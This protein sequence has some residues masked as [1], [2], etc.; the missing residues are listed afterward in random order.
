[1]TGNSPHH[2][3]GDPAELAA[4]FVAGAMPEEFAA[5]YQAHVSGCEACRREL[6]RLDGVVE[7]LMSDAP[8]VTPEAGAR[9]AIMA[10]L[11]EPTPDGGGSGAAANPQVWKKWPTTDSPTALYVLRKD[12]GGWEETGVQGVRVR[13]LHVDQPRN[14]ITM[15]VRMDAGAAYPR[16]VHN[17]P[18][19]CLVLEGDLHIVDE[20]VVLNAGDY[21]CAPV[22]SRHSVQRTE[23]GCLLMIV[24]SLTDE[25]VHD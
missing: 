7:A 14:Q 4:L 11:D 10:R 6:R 24:S 15:L 1:M 22:G 23:R 21:Q 18:E 8:P 16:H 20:Q 3:I 9:S 2:G 13:K 19:E 12:E 5:E 25:I 17:G